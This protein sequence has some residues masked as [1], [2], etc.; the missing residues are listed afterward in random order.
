MNITGAAE[1]IFLTEN[2]LTV[3]KSKYC[4]VQIS[5]DYHGVS[6]LVDSEPVEGNDPP[7]FAVRVGRYLWFSKED[8]Q[9][10]LD[11]L[12]N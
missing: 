12:N 10:E 2:W 5:R 6:V 7:W 1:P 4:H 8:A 11:A 3:Y 9:R